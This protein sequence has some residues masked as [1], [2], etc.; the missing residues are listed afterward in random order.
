[1]RQSAQQ[2]ELEPSWKQEVSRRIAEH[3]RKSASTSGQPVFVQPLHPA[4]SRAAAAAARVAAR[5]AKAPSYNEMLADEARSAVRAA[6]AASRAALQA[7]AV[8][9]SVLAGLEACSSASAPWEAELFGFPA[10][11]PEQ[12]AP[13]LAFETWETHNSR[14]AEAPSALPQTVAPAAQPLHTQSFE[15]RWDNDLPVREPSPASRASRAGAAFEFPAQDLWTSPQHLTSP[16]E[17]EGFELVEP[18]QPIHAN[19]IEFPRELVATRK[20]RPRRA[21][22]P[23]AHSVEEAGQLS[24]FEVDPGSISIDVA[25][26]SAAASTVIGPRWSGIELDEEP[27]REELDLYVPVPAAAAQAQPAAATLP[28]PALELAQASR[29]LLAAVVDFSLIAS[30]FLAVAVLAS[31]NIKVLPGIREM[32]IGSAVAFALIALFYYVVFAALA[33]AT[34]GMKYAQV[35]FLTFAGLRPARAQRCARLAA[36]LV[37]L[38]PA[39]LGVFW[40][41]FDDQHLCWHDRL[42]KTYPRKA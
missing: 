26:A 12:G 10:P 19:L 24:I 40:S 13:G 27:L 33:H 3:K 18:A 34:P 20:V 30:A 2:V 4:G 28:A 6:E 41:L 29:R 8:A 21:E 31:A 39:G 38:A 37:S 36:L 17:T 1:M 35:E 25:A 5:Y 22:G 14:G 23:Y 7:Q 16:L 15:I 9:E 11:A 32:E 42:S